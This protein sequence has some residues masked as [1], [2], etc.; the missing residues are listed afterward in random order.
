[1]AET[2]PLCEDTGWKPV[3]ADG[4]RRVARCE[5]WRRGLT[6][7]LLAEAGIAPQYAK[8]DLDN[9]RDYNDSLVEAVRRARRFIE[10]YPAAQK[11]LLFVGP[12]GVGKTHLAIAILKHAIS[13]TNCR[14][15]FCLTTGLLRRIKNTF[16]PVVKATEFDVIRP[17]M[18]AELLVLDDLG[19][20]RLTDWVDETMTLIIN[21]RYTER[22]PTIFTTNYPITQDAR[23]HAETLSE[24]IGARVYSRLHEMCDFVLLE[25][26]LD[27]R[28]LGPDATPSELAELQR[29]GS[30]SHKAPAGRSRPMAKARLPEGQL[31]LG[32]SGGK[33]GT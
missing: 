12:P 30:K 7:K 24:R 8:C 26:V 28:E 21:T 22:L 15:L 9:F 25:G 23:S 5:C 27:Y 17:V 13:T 18:E 20:E 19:A 32:W 16:N 31:D 3:E 2:C 11:G 10:R 33:A 4:V 6:A 1:M 29:R 14:G